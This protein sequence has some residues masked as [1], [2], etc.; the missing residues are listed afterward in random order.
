MD[1]KLEYER[2]KKENDEVMEQNRKLKLDLSELQNTINKSIDESKSAVVDLSNMTELSYIITGEMN[3]IIEEMDMLNKLSAEASKSA[4]TTSSNT[5]K[6][7]DVVSI[8]NSIADQTKLLAINATIE[9]ARAG[10]AGRGFAVV[11]NE[12]KILADNTKNSIASIKEVVSKILKSITEVTDSTT[13]IA[14]KIIYT[15][16]GIKGFKS[17]VEDGSSSAK[18][19][20]FRMNNIMK[21]LSSSN[22]KLTSI[23]SKIKHI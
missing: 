14:D 12:I 19:N 18:N 17:G 5:Q 6:I 9:A 22:R 11:A 23:I 8:I 10:E 13:I 21:D 15:T 3:K 4:E 2:I 16:Q 1:Y 7:E 20:E